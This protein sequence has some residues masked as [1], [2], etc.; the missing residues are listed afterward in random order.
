MGER[1]GGRGAGTNFLV[2]DRT[3]LGMVLN[4]AIAP[5]GWHLPM[6]MCR[7]VHSLRP[8]ILLIQP[9]SWAHGIRIHDV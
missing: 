8:I 9:L 4:N 3:P 2:V 7:F 6:L 1:D 5:N